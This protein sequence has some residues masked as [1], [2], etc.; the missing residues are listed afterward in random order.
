MYIIVCA[1][2]RC[3]VGYHCVCMLNPGAGWDIIVYAKP[4]SI[5]A[6]C[7]NIHISNL[8]GLSPSTPRI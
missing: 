8:V 1:K 6:S 5:D 2:P 4:M 7:Y 3:R